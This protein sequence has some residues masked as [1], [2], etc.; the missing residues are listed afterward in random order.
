MIRS[1]WNYKAAFKVALLFQFLCAIA[2]GGLAS[3]PSLVLAQ[4]ASQDVVD[5]AA[6]VDAEATSEDAAAL[7][8]LTP[9][10]L[11]EETSRQIDGWTGTVNRIQDALQ[12][13][14]VTADGLSQLREQLNLARS[15][16]AQ[17]TEARLPTFNEQVALLESLAP[18]DGSQLETPQAQDLRQ[19]ILDL[20]AQIQPVQ[21]LLGRAD[22]LRDTIS[23]RRADEFAQRL[24]QDATSVL[25]PDLWSQGIQ[26]F[27]TLW[28]RMSRVAAST[29]DGIRTRSTPSAFAGLAALFVLLIVLAIPLRSLAIKR[30]VRA[31]GYDA[32]SLEKVFAAWRIVLVS[33]G[34]PA[35]GFAIL[36]AALASMSGVPLPAR[37]VVELIAA[38]T[39]LYFF[40]SGIIRALLAPGR[41]SWRLVPIGETYS[42]GAVSYLGLTAA[43][44]AVGELARSVAR[45]F[46][47][48]LPTVQLIEA[49]AV[50]LTA[51][52]VL[53]SSRALLAG[54]DKAR[55]DGETRI[56][57][58]IIWRWTLPVAALSAF[59]ALVAQLFG[60]LALAAFTVDRIVWTS[61]VLA[62]LFLTALL[63][64]QVSI[65][66]FEEDGRASRWVERNIG[67]SH[68]SMGQFGVL[69]SGL[70]KIL[71]LVI[72]VSFIVAPFGV[73]TGE[74]ATIFRSVFTG[75]DIGGFS[76]SLTS[77]LVAIA[78]VMLGVLLTRGVQ[79]WLENRYL[80]RTALDSGLK[81]SLVTSIGYVGVIVAAMI[82]L[83]SLGLN[84]ENV[85]LVAGALSVGIG[86]GLQSI[87]SNFVSGL[88]LLA[89][90]PF[91]QGDWIIVGEEQGIVKRI[92]VR[93]TE[94][95]TFD[96]AT[97]LVP[98]SDFIAGSVKNRVHRDT[99]GRID[100]PVGVG[101]DSNPETVREILL[102]VAN[103]HPLTLSF[104]EP[105]VFFIE[106]GASSLDFMLFA[107][108]ADVGEGYGARS[109]IRF[110]IFKRFKEAGIEIPF[111]QSD[112]SIRN[113]DQVI[114]A[115][116]KPGFATANG[117][118]NAPRD[119]V[120]QTSDTT[121]GVTTVPAPEPVSKA[122]SKPSATPE[123]TA[124]SGKARPTDVENDGFEADGPAPKD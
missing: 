52:L 35:V 49:V 67:L 3:G 50:A 116:G 80:P 25:S 20:E 43:V 13:N 118:S 95:Q 120:L 21:V 56:V 82:A 65:A 77:V 100:I 121:S 111:A 83:S 10:P 123:A 99:L 66:I 87:V 105:A 92:S 29:V 41:S 42:A 89:E 76:F 9:T 37:R 79:G 107:Y 47:A 7:P 40:L 104:P 15:E 109:D 51:L 106:F 34:V 103:A 86:F 112:V 22:Q 53:I 72:A 4:D 23:Q 84:L 102:D 44:Y 19:S 2:L 90:R 54:L 85:A 117:L 6:S 108:L 88:I 39:I 17:F 27:P 45:Q 119:E 81:S 122:V 124:A 58:Q 8:A 74:F 101:Y 11:D 28:Q 33:V 115:L 38:T 69:L 1:S 12:Q 75:I 73:E 18:A 63:V 55:G 46:L 70:L 36:L 62:V 14:D 59:G 16:M 24:F 61:T 5:D 97:V 93:A 96:R 71:L 68:S 114:D 32:S 64:E 78:I 57:A 98:N 60:Y 31:E 91:K 30:T 113:L 26:E 110:E 94:I 48:P